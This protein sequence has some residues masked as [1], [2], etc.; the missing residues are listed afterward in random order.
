MERR[1][2]PPIQLGVRTFKTCKG[3]LAIKTDLRASEYGDVWKAGLTLATYIE[4]EPSLVEGKR[5]LELGSGVGTF[6]RICIN[7]IDAIDP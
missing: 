1:K 3:D 2:I 7:Y 4:L 6:G 5:V